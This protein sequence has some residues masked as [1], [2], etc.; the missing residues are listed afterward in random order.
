MDAKTRSDGKH[1]IEP[2][3]RVVVAHYKN[4]KA[5]QGV[6]MG[7]VHNETVVV[8]FDGEGDIHKRVHDVPVNQVYTAQQWL[9]RG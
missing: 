9:E 6:A 2:G 8:A 3:D 5:V 1:E 7:P 4:R